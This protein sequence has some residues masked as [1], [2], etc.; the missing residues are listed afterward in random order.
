[1]PLRNLTEAETEIVF[2]CLRCVATGEVILNDW[3]FQTLFGIEFALLEKIVEDIP[4]IDESTEEVQL[5]INNTFANLLGY[6]HGRHDR[7]A[8]YISAPQSEVARIFSKWRGERVGSYFDG[9]Q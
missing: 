4:N 2:E 7:W 8:K 3:E 6:P 1:M 9:I 5:A